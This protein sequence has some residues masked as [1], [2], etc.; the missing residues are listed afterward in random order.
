LQIVSQDTTIK[1]AD[2]SEMRAYLTRP[3]ENGQQPGIIVIHE[4]YGLNEQIR[5]VARRYAEEGFVALAP[6]L[7]TRNGEIMNEKNIESAMRKLWALPPE[8]MR[9]PNAIQELM[10][11]VPETDRKVME[12]FYLGRDAMEKQMA[13]DL[14]DCT[15]YL[16]HQS[17]V[18]GDK[19]GITGF[20]M[21]GGLAYQL[22]TMHNFSAVVPFYGANPK[23]LESVAN[24]TGPILA[25]YA[26]EDERI[27]S[28]IPSLVEAMLKHKKA[29]EMKVYK[30]M[31]HAFFNE[32]RPVYNKEA[33]DDAWQSAVAFFRKNLV[34]E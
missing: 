26:G 8:K 12:I 18:K 23:P 19:L 33:A 30:G 9:D 16:Q 13:T 29:F 2:G 31:Q 6:H 14:M 7:F 25:F 10:K 21:G 3:Q 5:G 22:A 20:C 4:A 34:S 28:G 11:T 24:I 1:C 15:D 17:F 27:N 32:T